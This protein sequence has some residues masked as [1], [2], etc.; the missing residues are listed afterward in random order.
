MQLLLTNLRYGIRMLAKKPGFTFVVVLTLALGIGANTAIFSVVNVLLLKPLP[1]PNDKELVIL[2]E[3]REGEVKKDR[4]V[5]YLNFIDWQALNS[6]FESMAI[7]QTSTA[8]LTGAGEPV[9]VKGAVVSAD[10]FKV[11]GIKPKLGRAF[12]S[13]DDAAGASDGLNPVMLT[14]SCWQNRFAGDTQIIGRRITLDEEAYSV[15]GVTPPEI[16]PL[17]EE[18]IDFWTTVAV[19]GA[20][21]KSGTANGSR[22]YPAYAG[23]LARLKPNV[24]LLQAQAEME[25]IAR[26]MQEKYPNSNKKTLVQLTPLRDLFVKDARALLLLLLGVVGAVLLIACVNVA[27][28]LLARATV[29]HREIAIR[30]A[31]G[32]GRWQ[33]IQ[34]LLTESLLV[35]L[36]GGA[37]GLGLS[38]WGVDWLV[39]LLPADI[40]RITGLTP[41][42]R[43]LLFTF[44][45]SILTGVLCGIIPAISASKIDLVE[46]IKESGRSAT[47]SGIRHKF[48]SSL[49]VAEIALA[50]TLLV[51]AGLLIKS[52]IHLQQVNPGFDTNNVL[53]AKIE[54][55]NSRYLSKEM[56]PDKINLFLNNLNER[57]NQIPGVRNVS[58][59]QCVPLTSSENNTRFNIV[60]NPFP[61]GE[62]P[63][64][65]LR[66][67]GLN[68]FKTIGIA[69]ISGRDFS[70]RDDP[71]SPPVVI[72]NEAFVRQY[73][74]GENPLGKTLTLGWGGDDPK[75]I[76]GVV[77]DVRHRSLSDTARPEMY[78][79]QAQFPNA[80]I[81]LLVR[82]SVKAESL[83]ASVREQVRALDAELPLTEIKT[84]EQYRDEAVA[85]P[86]FN[87]FLL[88]MFA[89]L[90]LILTVVGL[91]GVLS[92]SVTQR[93][94]EIGI[95]MA[96]GAQPMDV[97]RLV[98]GQG[99][100]LAIIGVT[101]GLASALLLTRFLESLLFEVKPSDP[102]VFIGITLLFAVVA[103][104]ACYIPARRATKVDPMEAL[105]YE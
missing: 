42:W 34:Q 75:E 41:D 47:A 66:F 3:M 43:V 82:S 37:F 36:A 14:Y 78:V 71:K 45:A 18:P 6:S 58:V 24:T 17:Q 94:N 62:S 96:L 69:Q 26:A 97:F 81:T 31:L 72:I 73:L 98:V 38:V 1:F 30:S 49:V 76:I 88:T 95:R 99:M 64:A 23:V 19:N 92:Y 20:A 5:S 33:I 50:M 4:G 100:K 74:N 53:T 101:L 60:Q 9:R 79:P 27:N 39:S 91:Y 52:L 10:F 57:L 104:L 55:S 21:N 67:I 32:A 25:N 86:R 61:K 44:G 90:A 8:A 87:T 51:S 28:L 77:G 16:F 59:A 65:Q 15:I 93:T 84:L 68:Y 2:Q 103:L 48:R 80:E 12:E 7:A 89:A 105:R 102:T 13:Q 29:R 63:S 35:G 56:K 83:I 54:L 85:M 46:A 40:P 70:E 22:G 11:L